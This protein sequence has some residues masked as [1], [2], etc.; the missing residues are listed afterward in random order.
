MRMFMTNKRISQVFVFVFFPF[1]L[2]SISQ[3]SKWG[4]NCPRRLTTGWM[5]QRTNCRWEKH[6]WHSELS[7]G[8][9]CGRLHKGEMNSGQAI[10][11]AMRPESCQFSRFKTNVSVKPD[12][13]A[14]GAQPW[15]IHICESNW[16]KWRK[17]EWC[18]H[19][20]QQLPVCFD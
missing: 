14:S 4:Q 5:F 12:C 7:D 19:E 6:H 10:Y 3:E 9:C 17:L 11:S 2:H 20:T 13:G 1:T 15:F 16:L 8:Y 18:F